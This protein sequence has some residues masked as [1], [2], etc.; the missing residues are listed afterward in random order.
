M[1]NKLSKKEWLFLSLSFFIALMVFISGLGMD[2]GHTV[3]AKGNIFEG[4][5]ELFQIPKITANAGIWIMLLLF[6]IAIIT[7]SVAILYV[8]RY[9][10]KHD[11]DPNSL[12]SWLY[13]IGLFIASF[14]LMLAIGTLFQ[15]PNGRIETYGLTLT[16]VF[17]ALVIGVL[18]FAIIAIFFW[19][20]IGT[21]LYIY[22][23]T[24]HPSKPL[25]DVSKDYDEKKDKV[26]N[27]EPLKNTL[28]GNNNQTIN[29]NLTPISTGSSLFN[30]GVI[31]SKEKVFTNLVAIDEEGPMKFFDENKE[32]I[33][34][35]DLVA[36]LQIY[37]ANVHNLYYNK[38]EL[39]QFIAG[40]NASKL[41]ILEG[42]SGT[43]KSSLPRYFAKFIG[44]DAFFEPIQVT[45]KEKSDLLG[46]YN[47]LTGRYVETNFLK[48]LYRASMNTERL[49]L[50]VLDEMNIS[51]IEYYFADFLSVME[52]PENER[53]IPI[54]S[55]PSDYNAPINLKDGILHITPNTYFI[56]TA[57][58]DD[59]TFTITDKVIDRAIVIDFED[60]QVEAKYNKNVTPISLSYDELHNLFNDALKTHPFKTKDR[61]V[62]LSLLK[63]ISEELGIVSG[64][65]LIKQIDLMVPV[66]NSMEIDYTVCL[67]Y[68]LA[69]KVLRKLDVVYD[70]SLKN[71]LTKLLKKLD[72]LYLKDQFLYS[73]RLIT[74]FIRRIS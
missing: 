15:I 20:L 6:S 71:Q 43:G 38:N 54:M 22:Q 42:I 3:F 33:T 60:T 62:F 34:L 68:F 63:F 17:G 70:S 47:E 4:F 19:A 32:K 73:K 2:A 29:T 67:D 50:M 26:T 69:N 55:L 56:G 21:L 65:R 30:N 14:A 41:I 44:E 45:Y 74:R 40:M 27:D 61:E 28:L 49:N 5:A 35:K 31:A 10:I 13:Y 66:Y 7:A 58:K 25:V 53:Q 39:A 59:S 16:Y 8:R 64:N 9:L 36:N 46:Y 72:E 12:V 24:V 23:P 37:L 57:N 48:E 11:K 18:L 52:F 1:K 51:R